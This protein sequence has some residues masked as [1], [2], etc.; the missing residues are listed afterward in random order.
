MISRKWFHT[1]TGGGG[2]AGIL[3][4][5][6]ELFFVQA[7]CGAVRFSW[8][9]IRGIHPLPI[10]IITPGESSSGCFLFQGMFHI[11]EEMLKKTKLLCSISGRRK[12]TGYWQGEINRILSGGN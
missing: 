9:E 3:C 4:S 12:L 6:L 8:G 1:K 10:T 7:G 5:G 11:I 2:G